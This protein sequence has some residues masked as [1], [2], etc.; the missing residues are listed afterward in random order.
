MAEMPESDMIIRKDRRAGR[1]T[2]NR[3]QALNALSH[4]MALAIDAALREWQDDPEVALVVID[5]EGERAF[6]SGGDI[7]AV[8]RAGLAGDHRVGR[9]FFRDEYRMNARIKD[10]PKP[11]V[12][13]MQGFVMGGGVGV[14]GHASHRIVGDTTQIAMPETGIGLIPDVGGSWLLG[15]APGR[16]GEYLGLTGARIGAGD[17]IF[18]GFA[19]SYIPEAEWP[20]LIDRLAETGD[21]AAIAPHPR[22]E[23]PLEGRDLS[24]FGGPSVAE[25]VAA[26]EAAGDEAA[27]KPLRRN[28]P[29]SMAATL[30]LVR[31]ARGDASLRD[32]LARELRFTARATA[33]SDFLEGVRAQI[34]D[35]DRNPQWSADAS[36]AHVAAMLAPLGED[37]IEWEDRT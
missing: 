30:A 27:L 36:P 11:I 23:A 1:L 24:A 26:L 17:A 3:P 4:E 25:I 35:K 19:D 9:E 2:F 32:S 6:C 18:T 7:A 28:S 14:G 31:A 13:F 20:A 33:E 10:Y 12:A 37:E 5:A 21:V 34:I 15:H 16:C 29:L 8:Y 22:P